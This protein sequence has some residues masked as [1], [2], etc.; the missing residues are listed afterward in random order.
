[1]LIDIAIK[2]LKPKARAAGLSDRGVIAEGRRADL[3]LVDN[4]VPL[5][6]RIIAVIAAGRLVHLTEA[7]RLAAAPHAGR[8]QAAVAAE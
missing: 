6:P 5:R 2:K 8:R 4:A 3:I 7:G 1:M